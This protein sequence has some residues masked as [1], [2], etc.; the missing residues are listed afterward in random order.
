MEL[1]LK[2]V[3]TGWHGAVRTAS[4]RVKSADPVGTSA[5][6]VT[7]ASASTITAGSRERAT[8]C[9]CSVNSSWMAPACADSTLRHQWTL[10]DHAAG[11]LQMGRQDLHTGSA[12]HA[13]Q[14]CMHAPPPAEFLT[15]QPCMHAALQPSAS[16]C[17]GGCP[18]CAW[19][20]S[21]LSTS[22]ATYAAAAPGILSARLRPACS[23]AGM[24]PAGSARSSCRHSAAAAARL[25]LCCEDPPAA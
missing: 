3:D 5:P 12:M 20:G 23:W 7:V 15:E 22:P 18:R 1:V 6:P 17:E 16:Q 21:F 19:C 25:T 11:F 4:W 10:L 9:A 13:A 2:K 24:S 8:Q 14:S